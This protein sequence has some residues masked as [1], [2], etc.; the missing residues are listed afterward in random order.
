MKCLW[1]EHADDIKFRASRW[2]VTQVINCR[3]SLVFAFSAKF[4]EAIHKSNMIDVD[5]ENS[6]IYILMVIST[7]ARLLLVVICNNLKSKCI[8]FTFLLKQKL[9]VEKRNIIF[10]S[11]LWLSIYDKRIYLFFPPILRRKKFMLSQLN[12]W[13]GIIGI[14][15]KPGFAN[16]QHS[17]VIKIGSFWLL[18]DKA[19]LKRKWCY[20]RDR[21]RCFV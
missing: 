7:S 1:T 9:F 17:R 2:R 20:R 4:V 18:P 11:L 15:Y 10:P 13:F 16:I 3:H 21:S 14:L 19:W 6:L 8:Y 12:I 5:K